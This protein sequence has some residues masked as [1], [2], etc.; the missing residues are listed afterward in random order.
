MKDSNGSPS[1]PPPEV[2]IKLGWSG[3]GFKT[4]EEEAVAKPAATSNTVRSESSSCQPRM[5]LTDGNGAGKVDV[6]QIES[7]V[8]SL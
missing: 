4:G 6:T 1:F 2:V 5:K 7:S 3:M 8:G